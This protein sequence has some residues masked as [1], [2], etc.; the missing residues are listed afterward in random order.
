ML[1]CEYQ[2]SGPHGISKSVRPGG[3]EMDRIHCLK[4]VVTLYVEPGRPYIPPQGKA[5]TRVLEVL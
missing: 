4:C 1:G 5:R 2:D 3:D